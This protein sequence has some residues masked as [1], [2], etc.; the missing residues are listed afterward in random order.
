MSFNFLLPALIFI[1][2]KR[3]AGVYLEGVLV[4]HTVERGDNAVLECNY[5]ALQH[6]SL[7]SLKWYKD[8]VEFY[9]FEPW[10]GREKTRVFDV[11]G[12]RVDKE[13]S[14]PSALVLKKVN[15]RSTGIYRCEITS[16]NFE[17]TEKYQQ[18]TVIEL[19]HKAPTITTEVNIKEYEVGDL[20]ELNCSSEPSNPASALSWQVNKRVVPEDNYIFNEVIHTGKKLFVTRI[21]LRIRLTKDH[22]HWGK[23]KVACLA[24]VKAVFWSKEVENIFVENPETHY[25]VL[26]SMEGYWI[27]NGGSKIGKLSSLLYLH[28]M[29]YFIVLK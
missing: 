19:P 7:Y 4:P 6:D 15:F 1:T 25:Q 2:V 9:R 27:G 29:L 16:S 22:F 8:E 24:Q 18:M 23:L 21:G 14:K 10:S 12:I 11:P 20:L 3:A 28:L 13:S 5:R 26:E 17:I